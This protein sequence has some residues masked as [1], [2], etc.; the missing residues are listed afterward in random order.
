MT[1]TSLSACFMTL[2]KNIKLTK[3]LNDNLQQCDIDW[4]KADTIYPVLKE[5]IN[6]N[7]ILDKNILEI[8]EILNSN[9]D[10]PKNECSYP[11]TK[12]EEIKLEL[13]GSL[14]DLQSIY[15]NAAKLMQDIN[16]QYEILEN[17]N[18]ELQK[19]INVIN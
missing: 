17:L 2:E 13:Q 5:I 19:V 6:N 15:M 11:K 12:L 9:D 1:K 16:N 7:E 4:G 3:V 14:I 10:L 18:V 8:S